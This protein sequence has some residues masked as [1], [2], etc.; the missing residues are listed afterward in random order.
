MLYDVGAAVVSHISGDHDKAQGH[1]VDAGVDV[2]A[3]EVP[4]LPA[5]L[6]KLKYT[7]EVVDVAKVVDKVDDTKGAVK[8]VGTSRAARRESMREKNI[9]TSQQPKSQNKNESG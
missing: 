2:V 6:T 9:P 3:M 1:W 7:D 5:G 8:K 4:G